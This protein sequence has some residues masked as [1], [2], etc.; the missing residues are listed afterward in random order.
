MCII[1]C[2]KYCINGHHGKKILTLAE[3]LFEQDESDSI[4]FEVLKCI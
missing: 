1:M 2:V 4:I 3:S